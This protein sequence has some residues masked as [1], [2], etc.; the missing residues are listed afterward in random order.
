MWNVRAE[1]DRRAV[2]RRELVERAAHSERH[3]RQRRGER[4]E[5]GSAAT[6]DGAGERDDVTR[7]RPAEE[8]RGGLALP[9][10]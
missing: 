10:L 6:I 5:L 7:D 9:L 1:A 2:G 8:D 4:D 3:R